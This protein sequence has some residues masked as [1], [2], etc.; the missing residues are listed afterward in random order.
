MANYKIT[1]VFN[2]PTH[3]GFQ[4]IYY[5]TADTFQ[6][7]LDRAT[8][9]GKAR[10]LLLSPFIVFEAMRVQDVT[11]KRQT[12][13]TLAPSAWGRIIPEVNNFHEPDELGTCANFRLYTAANLARTLQI[14]GLP[15]DGITWNPTKNAPDVDVLRYWNTLKAFLNLIITA[16]NYQLRRKKTLDETA[17][18]DY[19][20]KPTEVAAGDLA[21]YCQFAALDIPGVAAVVQVG[22]TIQIQG[23]IRE[24]AGLNGHWRIL[25]AAG[26]G[27]IVISAPFASLAA[28]PAHD[29]GGALIRTLDYVYENVVRWEAGRVSN[30]KP[31]KAFF[32]SPGRRHRRR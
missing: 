4:E 16:P 21:G 26:G 5:L 22:E 17:A 29:F 1:N 28:A 6:A 32:V 2:A 30:R 19:C 8:F 13:V 12:Y 23:C 25:Q 27:N 3:Q 14:R 10:A 24:G 31:G 15:D 9:F 20:G 11:A 7:A 18:W